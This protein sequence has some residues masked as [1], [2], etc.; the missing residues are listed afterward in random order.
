MPQEFK[1]IP[2][3]IVAARTRNPIRNIVDNLKV[4]PNPDKQFI[5]LALGDPTTFGNFLLDPT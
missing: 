2:C 3:S 5:S 1:E 4:T